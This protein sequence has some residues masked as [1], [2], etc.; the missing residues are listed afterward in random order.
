MAR[1]TSCSLFILWFI[2]LWVRWG[3]CREP[4]CSVGDLHTDDSL[5]PHPI[6]GLYLQHARIHTYTHCRN[7]FKWNRC[8]SIGHL[9]I[10][11]LSNLSCSSSL[12][13]GVERKITFCSP[14]TWWGILITV[15]EVNLPLTPTVGHLVPLKRDWS[16]EGCDSLEFTGITMA[17]NLTHRR[18]IWGDWWHTLHRGRG[19]AATIILLFP[20]SLSLSSPCWTAGQFDP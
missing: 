14:N 20:L 2:T 11:N 5:R 10:P 18:P 8:I 3:V 4:Q 16:G 19:S 1:L 15:K 12:H 7:Y 13:S 6:T 17:A 9:T